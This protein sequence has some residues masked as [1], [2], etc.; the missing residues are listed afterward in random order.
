M[1]LR[2]PDEEPNPRRSRPAA[3][4]LMAVPGL[5][6]LAVSLAII[7]SG[8]GGPSEA[9][10]QDQYHLVVI[11]GMVEQWPAIDVVNYPSATSPGYHAL[12][13]AVAVA[14]P[15]AGDVLAMRLVTAMIG[16]AL[17]VLLALALRR[18]VGAGAA[19]VLSLPLALSVYVL[20]GAAFL[21]T[22]NLA[23]GLL[24]GI[25]WLSL[26]PMSFGRGLGGGL[27]AASLVAVRQIH[28]WTIAPLGVA[29]LLASPL[30]R[31]A[32]GWARRER[33]EW[34]PLVGAAVG[35]AC[36]VVVLGGFVVAW[37]GLTPPSDAAAKHAGPPNPATLAMALAVFAVAALPLG[38]AALPEVR[39][40]ASLR[41]IVVGGTLGLLS[42]TLV[43]TSFE[44][45]ARAYGWIW[46]LVRETPA[47]WERSVVLAGL[48]TVGGAALGALASAS[49]R[50]GRGAEAATVLV[51][52][53]AWLSAQSMNSMAWQR[54]FEPLAIVFSALLVALVLSAGRER[55]RWWGLGP[56]ALAAL[57]LAISAATL[58]RE[59]LQAPA[60]RF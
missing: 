23:L 37:G 3:A 15:G 4:L 45:K 21:T 60:V 39:R 6:V 28:I 17:P 16:A 38:W 9:S 20:G 40:L 19:A 25:L 11:R 41:A 13:A 55:W 46:V 27:V 7:A 43:E 48:A 22:D 53:A 30:A 26:R 42:G 14:T 5:I 33:R 12:M 24:V 52:I 54:Y 35:G 57:Q 44:L 56:A 49:V 36:A 59:V 32:P 18:R 2:M 51:G 8:R 10:D 47:V 1:L 29:G 34:G 31:L 58:L 50:A